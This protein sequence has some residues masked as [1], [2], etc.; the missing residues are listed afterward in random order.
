MDDEELYELYIGELRKEITQ[1]EANGAGFRKALI[2][3]LREV[4]VTGY[5]HGRN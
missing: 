5:W 1:N 4:Y 3:A 2:S